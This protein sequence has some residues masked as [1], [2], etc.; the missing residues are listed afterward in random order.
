[1]LYI[2]SLL[3]SRSTA[4]LNPFEVFIPMAGWDFVQLFPA[5]PSTQRPIVLGHD[6]AGEIVRI[7]KGVTEFAIGDR[8]CVAAL[9]L[10]PSTSFESNADSE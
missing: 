7:G 6:F 2:I 1:M 8:V 10:Y 5:A 9:F 3:D 4:A